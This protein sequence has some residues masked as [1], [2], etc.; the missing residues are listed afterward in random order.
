MVRKSIQE[1]IEEEFY[2]VIEEIADELHL[3]VLEY[4]K[5]YYLHQNCKFENLI[6]PKKELYLFNE[7]KEKKVAAYLPKYNLILA[8]DCSRAS[9]GEEAGHYLHVSK[10]FDKVSFS[11]PLDSF[12]FMA[13]F[14]CFGYFC[15]KLVD[16]TRKCSKKDLLCKGNLNTRGLVRQLS[17]FISNL[18]QD[19]MNSLIHQQGY[20]LG[21][22]LYNYYISDLFSLSRIKRRFFKPIQ[23]E[24]D[25]LSNFFELKYEI[26]K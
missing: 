1:R 2:E 4:P 14:E 7:I 25:A 17:Y 12:S 13:L 3:R 5:L 9:L 6:L 18:N 15:S 22:K 20:L 26:L 19:E 8:K 11:N 21:E 23:N 10:T 16:S 24:T